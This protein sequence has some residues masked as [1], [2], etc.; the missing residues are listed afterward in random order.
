MQSLPG[1]SRPN[2]R[3]SILIILILL[4]FLFRLA[5]L[6][7]SFGS[8]DAMLWSQFGAD[9]NRLG[10]FDTYLYNNWMNHPPLPAL[11]AKGMYRSAATMGVSFPFLF[12]LPQIL[13]DFGSC[14]FLYLIFRDRVSRWAGLVAATLFAWNLDAILLSAFHCNTDPFYSMLCLAALWLAE[15]RRAA[16]W[17]GLVLGFAIN[18]KLL[19]ALFVAPFLLL[20]RSWPEFFRMVAALAIMSIPY[21]YMIWA[22]PHLFA[23]KV[24]GYQSIGGSGISDILISLEQHPLIKSYISDVLQRYR[25][26]AKILL[27]VGCSLPAICMRLRGEFDRYRAIAMAGVVFSVISPGFAIHYTAMV[28]A[29]FLAYDLRAG[30][31]WALLTG[32]QL[33]S[34]YFVLWDGTFPISANTV[35]HVA[36]PAK[37]FEFLAWG[38]AICWLIREMRTPAIERQGR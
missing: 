2:L 6:C 38:W 9:L 30:A 28:G 5:I 31:I 7:V 22:L 11:V 23:R 29:V 15:N 37:Y 20:V 10:L 4:G 25:D 21:L 18:I 34:F 26:S 35:L 36:G 12:K 14:F 1:S 17:A 24:I 32:L 27:L 3:E 8:T 19:P 33:L 13:A 16:F